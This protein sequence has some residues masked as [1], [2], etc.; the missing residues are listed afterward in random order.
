MVR[1]INVYLYLEG[2][3]YWLNGVKPDSTE[4][5]FVIVLRKAHAIITHN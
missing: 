3:N 5:A 1:E 2:H 4:K